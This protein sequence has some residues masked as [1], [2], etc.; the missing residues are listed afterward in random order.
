MIRFWAAAKSWKIP[1]KAWVL[2]AI[3]LEQTWPLSLI[4][5]L[6]ASVFPISARAGTAYVSLPCLSV[7]LSPALISIVRA[8]F[9]CTIFRLF[10]NCHSSFSHSSSPCRPPRSLPPSL[11]LSFL[12]CLS[13]SRRRGKRRALRPSW[14][15]WASR[16]RWPAGSSLKS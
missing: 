8:H 16:L 9:L 3:C 6:S 11:S 10:F 1:V 4:S 7:I 13:P 5:E 14:R 12:L 2:E 15:R